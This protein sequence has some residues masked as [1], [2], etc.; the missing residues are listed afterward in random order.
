MSKFIELLEKVGETAPSP[1]GFAAATGRDTAAPQMVL[2][3]RVLAGDL[4]D[5]PEIAGVD[6]AALLVE[7]EYPLGDSVADALEDR[8]WGVR[9][10][11]SP[12]AYTVEQVEALVERGCDFVV[13]ESMDTEAAVLN[14]DDLGRVVTLDV[15]AD[16][17]VA[18]AVAD[19]P[20]RRGAVPVRRRER[21]AGPERPCRAAEGKAARRSAVRRRSS[22]GAWAGRRGSH[23]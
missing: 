17:E 18:R 16:E 4:A 1:L 22:R 15:N 20:V 9:L 8:L 7:T 21:A 6:A 10:T 2:A 13:V 23:A 14:D 5:G 19:L 3:A 11:P 12:S